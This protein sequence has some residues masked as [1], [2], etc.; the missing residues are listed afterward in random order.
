M[1][2][3]EIKLLYDYNHWANGRILT[4]AEQASPAQLNEAL[5]MPSGTLLATLVHIMGAMWAWRQRTQG[6]ISPAALLDAS[7]F[8]TL[9][10]LRQR[11]LE[12][13]QAFGEFLD[14]LQDADLDRVIEYKNTQGTP[15]RYELWKIL[16]HVVNHSTQHRSEVALFLT[17]FGYSPGELDFT[18]FLAQRDAQQ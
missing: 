5:P 14:S 17:S 2:L 1:Q 3:A 15:F 10:V 7:Q 4:T 6:G 8:T 12:E 13:E 18:R 9:A 16:V 11:W